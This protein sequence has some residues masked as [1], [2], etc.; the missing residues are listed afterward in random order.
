MSFW[1][2][3]GEILSDAGDAVGGA[4]EDVG[5]A[6]GG[7][8]EDTADAIGGAAEDAGDWVGGAAEDIGQ[9][10]D[11]ITGAVSEYLAEAYEV[12]LGDFIDDIVNELKGGGGGD[13]G[14]ID[15]ESTDDA[16]IVEPYPAA[17][18]ADTFREAVFVPQFEY[19]DTFEPAAHTSYTSYLFG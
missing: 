11:E 12:T 5:E 16:L 10:I 15:V 9:V 1:D 8:A 7:A 17:G 3:V 4:A 18:L 19:A 13:D 2:D 6:I 14:D